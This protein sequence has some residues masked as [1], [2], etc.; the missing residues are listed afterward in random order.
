VLD[1]VGASEASSGNRIPFEPVGRRP[2]DA[3]ISIAD[4]SWAEQQLGWQTRL[5]LAAMCRDSWAWQ[6]NNPSGY[7]GI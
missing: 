1:V 7:A 6:S 2:G 5:D 3:A 4:P